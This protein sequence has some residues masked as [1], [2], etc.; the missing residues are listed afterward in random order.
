MF[1][2]KII[3]VIMSFLERNSLDVELGRFLRKLFKECV[4]EKWGYD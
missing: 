4:K 2:R 3:L 1:K